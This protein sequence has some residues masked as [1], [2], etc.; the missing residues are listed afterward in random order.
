MAARYYLTL[1]I[2]RPPYCMA[3]SQFLNWSRGGCGW[4]FILLFFFRVFF[5][6]ACFFL[7]HLFLMS[8]FFHVFFLLHLFS[9]TSFFFHIFFLSHLFTFTSFFFHIFFL[10][11]SFLFV[12][13]F[14][15][16]HLFA[17]FRTDFQMDFCSLLTLVLP[18][19]T[20]LFLEVIRWWTSVWIY[21]DFFIQESN[22]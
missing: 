15:F 11:T 13:Y 12:A 19:L 1:P 2:F 16:L 6:F 3:V 10:F 22:S 8:F 7:S 14:L 21:S 9:F 18:L 20:V 5:S 17:D 4:V